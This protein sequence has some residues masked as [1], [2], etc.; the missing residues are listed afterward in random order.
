LVPDQRLT[1]NES[2]Q[3]GERNYHRQEA[4]FGDTSLPLYAVLDPAS[5]DKP[6]SEAGK[7]GGTIKGQ[8]SGTIT[9]VP[10]FIAVLQNAQA[11]Q[12]A[13]AQ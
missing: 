6:V 3:Q 5:A 9:D 10:A 2:E 12:V 7:L 4:T 13:R 8:A 1:K 11:R